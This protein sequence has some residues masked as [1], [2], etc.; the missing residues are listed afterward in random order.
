MRDAKQLPILFLTFTPQQG[1]TTKYNTE[2]TVPLRITIS[3]SASP[4]LSKK[5]DDD[6]DI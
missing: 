4:K 1:T 5:V 2:I 6:D 3:S